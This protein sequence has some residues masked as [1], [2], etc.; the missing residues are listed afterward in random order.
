MRFLRNINN[1]TTRIVLYPG[2]DKEIL[3]RKKIWLFI[4]ALL[5]FFSLA[6]CISGFIE[7]AH[8]IVIVDILLFSTS[9]L[10]LIIFLFHRK[11]IEIYG[12][13]LQMMLVTLPAI[14]TYMYGG[15]FHSSGVEVVGLIGPVYALTFPNYRRAVGI[16]ILYL[17]FI[18]GG[19]FIYEYLHPQS[20]LFPGRNFNLGLIRFAS[21]TGM[22]FLIALIYN[23]QIARLKRKE[24]ERLRELHTAKSRFYT[25]ITHEFR[26]PLTIILGM[27]DVVSDKIKGTVE[28]EMK[29]IKNNGN[30]LLQLVNQLLNLSK[31]ED[32]AMP[33]HPVQS[34]IL[35]YL[36]YIMESFHSMAH[37]KNIRL[38][39]I[40]NHNSVIMDYDPDIIE[41]VMCNL[42]SNAIKFTPNGGDVYIQVEE[43]SPLKK[44][45]H[46]NLLI[47]V[48]DSGLGIAEDELPFIFDRF[49]QIDDAIT[50]R[51]EGTGIGLALVKE[52][53]ELLRGTIQV[54]SKPGQGTAFT[55]SLP[56]TQIAPLQ[57]VPSGDIHERAVLKIDER[58]HD[59]HSGEGPHEKISAGLP[60]VLIVEDNRD[61]VDYLRSTLNGF[62]HC[63]VAGNGNE[64]IYKALETVPDVI[65]CDI[66]MPEKDGFEVCRTLKADFRTNHIPVVIL[67]AKAD[68]DSKIGG[69]NC[70]ADAYIIK[71]FNKKELLVRMEK[72]IENRQKLKE[73]YG[74]MIFSSSI[75]GK[76]EG[77]NDIFIKRI[78]AT[79]EK[80]YR[81]EN[82][83]VFRFCLDMGI[84]RAQLH[85]KLIV[86]TGKSTSD[87]LRNYR[88][89]KA[90]ELL[91][92]SDLTIAEIAYN[93]GF[94][95]PN[96][97]SKSFVRLYGLTPSR[98]R[99]KQ[100]LVRH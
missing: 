46:G 72:L 94:R 49:Y 27:A 90:E 11:N 21:A 25:N 66:M 69:L 95:D 4:I 15:I 71:P 10:L 100:Q 81:D 52:Y 26:T 5:L 3:L 96:Y 64:G 85:R 1:W 13:L 68:M 57:Q 75:P 8:N 63:M 78:T 20:G 92:N 31:M 42:L 60:S 76:P 47:Y 82:Y 50:R 91:V 44:E 62:Y 97:F 29:M 79:L 40:S 37:D 23:L 59:A 45:S 73:K 38:H 17:V 48:R 28:H 80:N 2:D 12:L 58:E 34:D 32:G 30:K 88:I 93:A 89:R 70:G 65:I 41:D 55:L 56:V 39:F 98:Y 19:T 22:I 99:T 18:L 86:L 77:L 24:E 83:N 51:S 61:V 74:D 54:K 7:K 67:T 36:K 9:C 53:M 14:K 43:R 84:S 6:D 87:L 16:F 33:V 35:V